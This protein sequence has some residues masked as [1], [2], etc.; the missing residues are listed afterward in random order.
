M[1]DVRFGVVVMLASVTD[2]ALCLD[3][4]VQRW[5]DLRFGMLAQA[6]YDFDPKMYSQTRIPAT[7]HP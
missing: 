3:K 1:A 2:A 5:E 7:Q 6:L 4:N